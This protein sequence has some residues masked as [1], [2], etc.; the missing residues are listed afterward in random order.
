MKFIKDVKKRTLNLENCIIHVGRGHTCGD[1]Q[2]V[3]CHAVLASK[4]NYVD[5]M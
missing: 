3:K 5:Q 1:A 4:Q 2:N